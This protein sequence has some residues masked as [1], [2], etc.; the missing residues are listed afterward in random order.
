MNALG[1]RAL[2]QLL[3]D[4]VALTE[5]V[6]DRVT[7][8]D[9]ELDPPFPA[10]TLRLIATAIPGQLASDSEL[11]NPLIELAAHGTTSGQASETLDVAVAA[12]APFYNGTTV[13]VGETAVKFSSIRLTD[14]QQSRTPRE[15]L[16][17]KVA[18]YSLWQ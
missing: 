17:R 7:W 5:A 9:A 16:Y 1:E 6:G 15:G 3:R 12:L 10:I 14:V 11:R 18:L 13:M 2:V 8:D 4:D